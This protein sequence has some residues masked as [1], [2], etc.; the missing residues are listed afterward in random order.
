VR[1]VYL[2]T[3]FYWFVV[4]FMGLLWAG[5]GYVIWGGRGAAI[6]LGLYAGWEAYGV[7]RDRVES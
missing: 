1:P 6:C 2:G 5:V 7:A 4:V 3:W